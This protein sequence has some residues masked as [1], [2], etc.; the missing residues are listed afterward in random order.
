MNF[1]E[2]PKLGLALGLAKA[3]EFKIL[4]VSVSQYVTMFTFYYAISFISE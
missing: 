1:L 4:V 3:P 2:L